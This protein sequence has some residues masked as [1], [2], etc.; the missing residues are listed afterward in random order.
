MQKNVSKPVSSQPST[1]N[2]F[3]GTA[4]GPIDIESDSDGE[5]DAPSPSAYTQTQTQESD[6][7]S[8]VEGDKFK[9]ILRSS[10]NKDITLTVRSTTKC[11]AIIKAFLKKLGL[12]DQYP[13]IFGGAAPEPAPKK[14]K[15]GRKGKANAAAPGSGKDPRL[16][17]DGD[18]MDNGMEIG[19]QDLEDGDMVEVVGL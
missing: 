15:G 13:E 4:N 7:E 8:E 11:G 10:G 5:N 16:C 3:G 1:S 12:E 9:L 6:A 2:T 18:R 19:E 17:I 14:G